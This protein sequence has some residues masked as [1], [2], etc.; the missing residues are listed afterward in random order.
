MLLDD[1][2]ARLSGGDIVAGIFGLATLLFLAD[3]LRVWY[4]LS[5]VPGPFWASLSKYWMVRESLKGQQPYAIQKANEKYG[6][7]RPHDIHHS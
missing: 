4:R 5:H 2:L 7:K 6:K 1:A 3:W